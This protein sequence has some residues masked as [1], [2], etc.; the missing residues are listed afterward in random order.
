MSGRTWRR[1]NERSSGAQ[2]TSRTG[3]GMC[4]V[5]PPAS[6]RQLRGVL[7]T[8][9]PDSWWS[10]T[11]IGGDGTDRRQRDIGLENGGGGSP[12]SGE[13]SLAAHRSKQPAEQRLDR[14]QAQPRHGRCK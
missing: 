9:P 1:L 4:E 8:C 12:A 2:S 14:V 7:A 13:H 6:G 5:P 10:S 11:A 3:A